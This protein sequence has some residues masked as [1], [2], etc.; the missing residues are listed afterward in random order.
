MSDCGVCEPFLT[1]YFSACIVMEPTHSQDAHWN[2]V[3][4]FVLIFLSFFKYAVSY[5]I[6]SIISE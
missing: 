2:F 1:P 4:D 6:K 3:V 5:F